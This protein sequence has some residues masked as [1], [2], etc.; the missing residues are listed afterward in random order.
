MNEVAIDDYLT[1]TPGGAVTSSFA[2]VAVGSPDF[3][4]VETMARRGYDLGCGNGNYCP[5]EKLTRAELATAVIRAKLGNVFP[6]AIVGCAAGNPIAACSVAADHFGAYVPTEK[7]YVR[8]PPPRSTGVKRTLP[9]SSVE[10]ACRVRA[11][12][13]ERTSC[14]RVPAHARGHRVRRG[15]LGLR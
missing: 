10:S 7:R 15:A 1:S 11:G 14:P 9:A 5:T 8:V 13:D 6:A 4:Y 12:S 2:D 3:R